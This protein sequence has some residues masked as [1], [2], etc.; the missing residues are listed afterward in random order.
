MRILVICSGN[1]CRS[2]MMEAILKD[3][4][5]DW[6]VESAGIRRKARNGNPMSREAVSVLKAHGLTLRAHKS[7]HLDTVWFLDCDKDFVDHDVTVWLM[8]GGP[9]REK[10]GNTLEFTLPIPNPYG[11][12]PRAYERCYQALDKAAD[13]LLLNLSDGQSPEGRVSTRADTNIQAQQ[14]E[15]K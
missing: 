2:P 1:T 13:L 14:K 9:A 4:R 10:T 15:H 5:P 11:K 8:G 12:G 6:D 3:K 7:R